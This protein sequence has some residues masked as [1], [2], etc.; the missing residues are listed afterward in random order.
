M[1][2]RSE[3]E[4]P[5]RGRIR[6]KVSLLKRAHQRKEGRLTFKHLF[7]RVRV[8]HLVSERSEREIRPLRNV[9]EFR[10]GRFRDSSA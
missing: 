3:S 4:I 8:D 9:S 5:P 1:R 6:K 7:A 10:S 2:R